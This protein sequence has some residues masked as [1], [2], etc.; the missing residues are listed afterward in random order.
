MKEELITLLNN[1]MENASEE[2]LQVIRQLLQGVQ[3]K[4]QGLHGS[5]IGGILDMKKEYK[6]DEFEVSIPINDVV[7][8][9]MNIVHGGITAT[10]LDSAMGTLANIAAPEGYGAVTTNLSIHYLAPGKLGRYTARARVVHQGKTTMVLEGYVLRD[11]GSRAAQCTG[12]FFI[13]KI[14]QN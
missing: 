12:S 1:C 5:Y 9:S 7:Y 2:E 10:I 4:K 3:S 14:P 11:D 13:V 6:E 8:N